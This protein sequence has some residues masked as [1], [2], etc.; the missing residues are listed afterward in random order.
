MCVVSAESA[1]GAELC[2]GVKLVMTGA[3]T[4][5]AARSHEGSECRGLAVRASAVSVFALC[6]LWAAE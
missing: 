1:A 5:V 6:L 4:S 2:A 3:G